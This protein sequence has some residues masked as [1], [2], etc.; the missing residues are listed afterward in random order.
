MGICIDCA[1][2]DGIFCGGCGKP[3]YHPTNND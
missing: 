3:V 2:Y 1:D